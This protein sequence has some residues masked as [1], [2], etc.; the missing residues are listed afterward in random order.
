VV[1]SCARFYR[2]TTLVASQKKEIDEA[3]LE[4]VAPAIMR[5]IVKVDPLK[6]TRFVWGALLAWLPWLPSII[7]F[8]YALR[9]ISSE[10][11]TGLAAIAGGLAETFLV[12]GVFATVAAEIAALVLLFRAFKQGHWLRG[13]FSTFSIMVGGLMLFS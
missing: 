13:L 12:I 11:A 10:K 1:S 3:G 6:K 9:G 5:G 7:G 8:G 2:H 4:R